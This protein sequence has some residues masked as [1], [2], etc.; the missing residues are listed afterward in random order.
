[1]FEF[2]RPD[3]PYPIA[4]IGARFHRSTAHFDRAVTVRLWYP[5]SISPIGSGI[6]SAWLG[7]VAAVGVKAANKQFPLLL[8]F[9]GWNGS[10][11]DNVVLSQVLASHGFVVAA[12]GYPSGRNVPSRAIPMDFS[13]A[14]AFAATLELADRRARLQAD[15]ASFVL[16]MLARPDA[17]DRLRCVVDRTDNACV[18]VFGFSFGGAVAAQVAWQDTRVRAI[19]NLD[20]WL[21]GDAAKRHF[22]QPY[23]IVSDDAP[24]PDEA[25]LCAEDVT[26]RNRAQLTDRDARWQDAQLAYGGGYKLTVLRSSH[27]DFCDRSLLNPLNIIAL[28]Y[29][30]RARRTMRIVQAYVLGFF[31]S[32]LDGR[33]AALLD[34]PGSMAPYPEARFQEFGRPAWSSDDCHGAALV[35]DAIRYDVAYGLQD[36][37]TAPSRAVQP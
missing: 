4:M 35:E 2:P 16:D 21:F 27:S 12:I 7:S 37:G 28:P 20:G 1:M 18:G 31:G 30:R 32:L 11:H 3:G 8:G 10:L 29:T 24:P 13:S 36:V 22:E 9:A 23:L 14:E 25:E 17:M 26:R 33:P 19:M 34:A 15:T 6:P 5:A